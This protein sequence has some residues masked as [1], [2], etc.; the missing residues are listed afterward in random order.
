MVPDVIWEWG[1]KP[2]RDHKKVRKERAGKCKWD[3]A[4]TRLVQA[5][6]RVC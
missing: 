4:S 6:N 2:A 3:L 5:V 1:I